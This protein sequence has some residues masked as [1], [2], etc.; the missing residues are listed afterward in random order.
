M[1]SRRFLCV[2]TVCVVVV[3]F[4]SSVFVFFVFFYGQNVSAS[5]LCL[6]CPALVLLLIMC[7]SSCSVNFEQINDDDDDDDDD[8][9]IINTVLMMSMVCCVFNCRFFHFCNFF[10]FWYFY[11]LVYAYII[12]FVLCIVL[13]LSLWRI[14]FI[15]ISLR[16]YWL[17]GKPFILAGKRRVWTVCSG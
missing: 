7:A 5:F 2:F 15:V 11:S 1:K 16:D 14:N 17:T 12:C 13:A 3:V 10:Y 9:S 8:D 4:I 6:S